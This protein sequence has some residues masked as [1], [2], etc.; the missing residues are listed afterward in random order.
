M[1]RTF[2]R[3][4]RQIKEAREPLATKVSFIVPVMIVLDSI[5]SNKVLHRYLFP[6]D[7]V[8]ISFSMYFKGLDEE[9]EVVAKLESK[10]GGEYSKFPVKEGINKLMEAKNI[11]EGTMV[12]LSVPDYDKATHG[13]PE[14]WISYLYRITK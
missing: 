3:Q 11:P 13:N 6:E 14:V 5:P 12:E 9:L 8:V 10:E 7:A 1:V 2:I 4:P